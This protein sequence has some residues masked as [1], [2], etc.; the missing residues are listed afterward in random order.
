MTREAQ[1]QSQIDAMWSVMNKASDG[2]QY[3][4]LM[5]TRHYTPIPTLPAG[6]KAY[7][8]NTG[9][10]WYLYSAPDDDEMEDDTEIEWP[11]DVGLSV[12]Q[13]VLIAAGY[14]VMEG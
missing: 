14:I 2:Y 12:S 11:F 6:H 13:E 10:G 9:D 8:Y 3:G 7:A 4:L 1:L 5:L